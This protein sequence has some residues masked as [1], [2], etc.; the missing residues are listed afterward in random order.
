MLTCMKHC[1]QHIMHSKTHIHTMS[2]KQPIVIASFAAGV[3][4]AIMKC[5]LLLLPTMDR[6]DG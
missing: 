3:W 1:F 6:L 4:V 2:Y 5:H